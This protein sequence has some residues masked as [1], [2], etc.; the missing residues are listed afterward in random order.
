M[1]FHGIKYRKDFLIKNGNFEL[2]YKFSWISSLIGWICFSQMMKICLSCLAMLL[3]S[4]ST[5]SNCQNPNKKY[6]ECIIN[7]YVNIIW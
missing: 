5:C 1:A 7:L 2:E 6:A 3:F 4:L